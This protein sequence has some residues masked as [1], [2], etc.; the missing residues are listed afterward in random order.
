MRRRRARGI[1]GIERLEPGERVLATA[2]G[3]DG[4]VTA[5]TRRLVLPTGTSLAW[6]AI[7]TAGWDRAESVLTVAE[8]PVTTPKGR[9]HRL[10][11]DR[12]GRLTDVVREQ[13]TA[14]VVI[15]RRMPVD[16]A[17]GV[18]VTG[19]RTPDDELIWSVQL[20]AGIDID[21]P[22]T[23]A[24]VDEAVALVRSEVE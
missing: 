19:R 18:R 15:S 21:D 7:E 10:R 6:T 8:V 16:G 13:V 4:P 5:T 12:P 24:R 17:R 9:R 11:L 22:A 3:P 23:R 20:D 14:S 1:E 2:D